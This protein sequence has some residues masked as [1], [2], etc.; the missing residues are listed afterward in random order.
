MDVHFNTLQSQESKSNSGSGSN[1]RDQKDLAMRTDSSKMTDVEPGVTN[2]ASSARAGRR[3][4]LPDIQ[5][6]V[7]TGGTSDLPLKLEALSVKEDVKKKD[8]ETTQDKL[9]KPQNE[10]NESS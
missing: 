10:G 8:E 2:F 6:L 7:A 9:E 5:S 3:N 4:A 1:S